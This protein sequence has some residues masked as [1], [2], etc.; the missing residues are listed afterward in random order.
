MEK[1]LIPSV[2]LTAL[3]LPDAVLNLENREP[4]EIHTLN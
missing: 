1:S 4:D 3:S 2:I